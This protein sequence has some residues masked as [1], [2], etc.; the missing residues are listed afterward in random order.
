MLIG[1]GWCW[2]Q[3]ARVVG[4][5]S[6]C[7]IPPWHRNV[8]RITG[9][10]WGESTC[11]WIPSPGQQYGVFIFPLLLSRTSYW[12]DSL[13]ADKLR[14]HN[15]FWCGVIYAPLLWRHNGHDGVSNHQ[16]Y[17]CLLN[18]LFRRRSKKTSKLRVTGL[19][20]GN[21]SGPVNSPHKWPVT[22]KMFPFDDV[23]MPPVVWRFCVKRGYLCDS[24]AHIARCHNIYFCD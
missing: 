17:D 2:F 14:R 4:V 16:P 19:C 12:T 24:T 10:L 21:S 23:I 15:A 13:A 1:S 7:M 20:A 9:A 5:W 6:R 22:R 8:S 18:R 11:R 3:F